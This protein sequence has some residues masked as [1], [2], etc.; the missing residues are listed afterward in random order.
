MGA[1][2]FIKEWDNSSNNT[3]LIS[4]TPTTQ[5]A[6]P[7]AWIDNL[8]DEKVSELEYEYRCSKGVLEQIRYF[9]NENLSDKFTFE[10]Y[11][12]SDSLK[13]EPKDLDIN[14]N[15]Y[16][17]EFRTSIRYQMANTGVN[18][19]GH[20]S[21]VDVGMTGWGSSYYII[22]RSNGKAYT[23]PYWAFLLD[24]K[25]DSNLI[26]MNPKDSFI[27]RL[28]NSKGPGEYCDGR[29]F[30]SNYDID[31]SPF[32]FLW[33][34]NELKLLGPTNIKPPINEFWKG[35]FD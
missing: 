8:N 10:R 12:V 34:N 19:A 5:P 21:L 6:K 18:F 35:Y 26:V 11:K 30:W 7:G 20:Y 33:E 14:S 25:T 16:A 32:Y 13:I 4:A 29:P 17:R 22:D 3:A 24:F 31:A 27:E 1:L 23:F 28:Q 2:F 9:N 15:R